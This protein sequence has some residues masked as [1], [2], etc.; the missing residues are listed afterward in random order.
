MLLKESARHVSIVSSDDVDNS[1]IIEDVHVLSKTT[2]TIEDI[3]VSSDTRI[4]DEDHA[5]YEG[6]SE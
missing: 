1:K 5:S 6:I 3:S 2:S 4:L